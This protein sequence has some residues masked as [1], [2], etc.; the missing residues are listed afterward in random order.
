[1][2][3]FAVL[4]RWGEYFAVLNF[5]VLVAKVAAVRKSGDDLNFLL[6]TKSYSLPT[7]QVLIFVLFVVKLGA[8]M[9]V[10]TCHMLISDF[11]P[12]KV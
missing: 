9:P 5:L 12:R 10:V 4:Q 1:M 3:N 8:N 2:L 6:V 7:I 11:E